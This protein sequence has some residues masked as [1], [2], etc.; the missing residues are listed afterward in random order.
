M[1][2]LRR[3]LP[4]LN[5]LAVFEAA[6][7][8][9]SLTRAAE[10]LN[11]AQSAVSRHV[12][13]LESQ[14]GISLF[15]RVGNQ[16]AITDAGAELADAI[17][18]GLGQIRD[19]VERLRR[20]AQRNSTLTIGCTHAVAQE[21]LMPRFGELRALV[22]NHEIRLMTSDQYL[23]LDEPDVDFS[24]RYGKADSWPDFVCRKLFDEIAFPVCAPSLLDRLPGLR[25]NDPNSWA[26][27]P[28]LQ[29]LPGSQGAVDWRDWFSTIGVAVDLN[30]PSFSSYLPL[31]MEAIAGHGVALGWNE[32]VNPHLEAGRLVRLNEVELSSSRSFFL[33]YREEM[34]SA[35]MDGIAEVL[36]PTDRK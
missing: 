30:G 5:A 10:E 20:R 28:L 8:H 35:L 34:D 24:V 27:A 29:L 31:L 9:N 16:V 21:W 15:N 22:P 18:A 2:S 11:I 23:A 12:S 14:L 25:S 1:G 32:F 17:S 26:L 6:A 3:S 33:V 4:A 7:R 13:N 19:V 36:T